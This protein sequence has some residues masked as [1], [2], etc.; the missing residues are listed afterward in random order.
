MI[1]IEP[2]RSP[3]LLLPLAL[4]L[5]CGG[6]PEAAPEAPAPRA[7]QP[8]GPGEAARVLTPEELAAAAHPR[9]TPEDVRF[10]QGMLHHHAQALVMTE[11]A[12]SDRTGSQDIR[13]L[14]RRIELSQDDEIQLMRRWLEERGEEVP[15]ITVSLGHHGA[16]G[17]PGGHAAHGE[18]AAHGGDDLPM[19]GM[20]SDE[21]LAG[22]AAATGREFDRLFLQYMIRHHEGA[23]Q[24]VADLFAAPASGQEEEMFQFASHVEADQN[25]EIRRMR[26]MLNALR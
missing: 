1:H 5:A 16:H 9:H 25:I 22:L 15:E 24:M 8:G 10:M 11:L 14:A 18:H 6:G 23:V 26:G 2:R 17:A 21:E 4:V 20:L 3:L 12:L 7:L 19:H 13:L